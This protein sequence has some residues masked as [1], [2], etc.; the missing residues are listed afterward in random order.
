MFNSCHYVWV[1]AEMHTT[2]S[3]LGCVIRREIIVLYFV[4]MNKMWIII[5]LKNPLNVLIKYSLVHIILCS[6]IVTHNNILIEI[7]AL[8]QWL[9]QQ[10]K[11]NSV[12]KFRAFVPTCHSSGYHVILKV[13]SFT[14]ILTYLNQKKTCV[15]ITAVSPFMASTSPSTSAPFLWL[16]C[17][18]ALYLELFLSTLCKHVQQQ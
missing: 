11:L 12:R 16:N 10:K 2:C 5:I 15:N 6:V 1:E 7:I 3:S 8:N 14:L 13:Y 17:L 9:W 18:T 4:H